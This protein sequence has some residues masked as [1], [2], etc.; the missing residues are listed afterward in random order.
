MKIN[1]TAG[2][3][4]GR[5]NNRIQIQLMCGVLIAALIQQIQ[6]KNHA[7][8]YFWDSELFFMS[9][10]VMLL[11]SQKTPFV[12]LFVAL[13]GMKRTY[14]LFYLLSKMDFR[15]LASGVFQ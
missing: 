13:S 2:V 12:F 15:S 8:E 1:E 7:L 9:L 14:L 6:I 4:N 10:I 5:E 3:F 11:M